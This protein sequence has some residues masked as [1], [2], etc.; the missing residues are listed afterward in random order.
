MKV[1]LF[2]LAY[3]LPVVS[4]IIPNYNYAKFLNQR[5]DSVLS[6]TF[7][8]IELI[9][10]DDNS[11]DNSAQVIEE[12]R[13]NPLVSHIVFNETNSGSTFKQWRKGFELARGEFIWIAEADDYAAPTLLEKL[14]NFMRKDTCIKVGF[15]NSNWVTPTSTFV[16]KDYTIAE[17]WHIYDGRAFVLEHLLKENYIYNASMALFRKDAIAGVND[18][19]MQFRSCGDKIFWRDMALQGK[20]LYV[21]EP[22]NNFRIHDAKVTTN[23][24]SSGLLFKEEHKFF[25][26]N[27][28][29]GLVGVSRRLDVV[30]YFIRY[31]E[32]VKDTLVSNEVYNDVK[33]M[34]LMEKDWHNAKLPLFFRLYCWLS[35]L[36]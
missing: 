31:I 34:W 15:V 2:K 27:I 1:L 10:L 21:C 5:I 12:Y 32:N 22:L 19:Y 13:A 35:N 7:K 23:A 29:S 16:N 24:I 4:V 28:Q 8:D 9:I 36:R 6:Q 11:Q 3:M 18:V 14:L 20:V 25:Y 33:H 30:R 26:M 17:P